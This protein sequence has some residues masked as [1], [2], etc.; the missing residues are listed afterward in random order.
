[1]QLLKPRVLVCVQPL[2]KGDMFVRMRILGLLRQIMEGGTAVLILTA[3]ISDTLDISD[4][5]LVAEHGTCAASYEK[6]QFGQVEW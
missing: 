2:A 6:E 5:L 1:M 3:N 4:R